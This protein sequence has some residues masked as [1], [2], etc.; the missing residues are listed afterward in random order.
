MMLRILCGLAFAT[1]CFT[2]AERMATT[3]PP[4]PIL[5]GTHVHIVADDGA[6]RVF[7]EIG[8]AHV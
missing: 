8:R 2:Q 5:G 3:L 1:G 4:V 7:T 6:V